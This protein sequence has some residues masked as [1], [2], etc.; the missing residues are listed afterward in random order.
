M[1][2]AQECLR[3]ALPTDSRTR[4]FA[5]R[6][7]ARLLITEG[8]WH[9]CAEQAM[10]ALDAARTA[11]DLDLEMRALITAGTALETLGDERGLEMLREAFETAAAHDLHEAAAHAVN[12]LASSFNSE[13][14][15]DEARRAFQAGIDF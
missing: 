6:L 10:I 4:A 14:R 15:V 12:N 11:A 13:G 1:N 7:I 8:D 9:R 2:Y 5:A 3:V